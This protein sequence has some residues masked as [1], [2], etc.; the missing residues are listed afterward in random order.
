[1]WRQGVTPHP[2]PTPTGRDE[3]VRGRGP[4]PPGLYPCVVSEGTGLSSPSPWQH[5]RDTRTY[6]L[7]SVCL[8][9]PTPRPSRPTWHNTAQIQGCDT[10]H[11]PQC[12]TRGDCGHQVICDVHPDAGWTNAR[13]ET[14]VVTIPGADLKSGAIS[15]H[16]ARYLRRSNPLPF[17]LALV[18]V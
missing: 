5:T 7:P 14:Y 8:I 12:V 1:M 17:L 11:T 18:I 10:R 16:A 9:Q 4:V 15:L 2:H 6:S 13:A 3:G